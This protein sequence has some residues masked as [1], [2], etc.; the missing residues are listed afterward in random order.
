M[1]PDLA[2]ND[3]TPAIG[4]KAFLG[5]LNET[6]TFAFPSVVLEGEVSEYRPWKNLVFF[7]VKE[8]D[9]AME[10]FMPLARVKVPVED[11]MKVRLTGAPKFSGKGRYS[12]NGTSLELAGEGTLKRAFDL[13]KA[14]LTKEGLFD[15][16]RK[17]QLPRFP[18]RLGVV[19]ASHS[20]AYADFMKILGQRWGGLDVVVADVQ[21][22]GGP[23]ADQVAGGIA[24]MNQLAEPVDVIVVIRGGGSLEDLQA[25]NT[26]QVTRAIA[27]SRTPTIVGVG[28]EVD[29]SLADY[30]ADVRAATPTDAARLVVPDRVQMQQVVAHRASALQQRM[31]RAVDRRRQAIAARVGRLDRFVR[32]PRQRTQQLQQRLLSH[33]QRVLAAQRHKVDLLTRLLTSYDPTATLKRGY[34]IVRSNGK[35]VTDPAAAAA[36]SSLVVQLAKG[37][38]NVTVDTK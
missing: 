11:G 16:G 3:Q 8:G 19:T 32:L 21:V 18:A 24:Y 30:A 12:F 9:A 25:F 22:Q 1:N 28:H 26:E 17:R 33:Q 7:K 38:I 31:E 13:L 6:L 27:G 15:P 37:D 4:V 23:A 35:V 29:V 10:C 5:I 2:V 14:Q 20:A 34:A 36:G